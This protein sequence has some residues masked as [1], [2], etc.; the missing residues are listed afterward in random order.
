MSWIRIVS[1]FDSS[2]L[3]IGRTWCK[4]RIFRL[5]LA[6]ERTCA[7]IIDD[8]ERTVEFSIRP[9]FVLLFFFFFPLL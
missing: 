1:R 4:L 6:G 8:G 9:A 5:F 3:N 2:P 7:E